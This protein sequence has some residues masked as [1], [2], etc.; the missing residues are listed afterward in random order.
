MSKRFAVTLLS[1][2]VSTLLV[3]YAVWEAARNPDSAAA[4]A[5]ICSSCVTMII[6]GSHGYVKRETERPSL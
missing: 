5:A 3:V 1:K 4:I 6:A 2:A